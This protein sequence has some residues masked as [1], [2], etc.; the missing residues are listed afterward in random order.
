MHDKPQIRSNHW[1]LLDNICL[2]SLV[3]CWIPPPSLCQPT[4]CLGAMNMAL[5][6]PSACTTW[7]A[8]LGTRAFH[9]E[10]CFASFRFIELLNHSFL[11]LKANLGFSLGPSEN[12]PCFRPAHPVLLVPKAPRICSCLSKSLC[13]L[14]CIGNFMLL[15]SWN[16]FPVV[17]AFGKPCM[18]MGGRLVD[19]GPQRDGVLLWAP[20]RNPPSWAR[21]GHC[22]RRLWPFQ[23]PQRGLVW[24]PS[25]RGLLFSS[26]RV[27][28]S[29]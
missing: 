22:L 17:L 3:C 16:H 24:V 10:Y 20:L 2:Q 21:S 26:P 11:A 15:P 29:S 27:H 8:T 6:M 9:K 19:S 1:W 18:G 25:P 7:W 23:G 13:D 12:I 14:L 5:R 28:T 4:R